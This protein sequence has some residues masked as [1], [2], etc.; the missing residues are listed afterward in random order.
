MKKFTAVIAIGTVIVQTVGVPLTAFLIR[1]AR[2]DV[3]NENEQI[4]SDFVRTTIN[5]IRNHQE[6]K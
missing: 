2:G 6:S 1:M 5:K 3:R 4:V